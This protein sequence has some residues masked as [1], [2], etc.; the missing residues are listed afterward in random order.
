MKETTLL[1]AALICSLAGLIALFYISAKI[2]FKDYKPGELSKNAGESV[3]LE[4]IVSKIRQAE[5][6]AFIEVNFE[7]PVTI[8]IFNDKNLTL[9]AGD[10]IEIFGKVED[11]NGKEEIIAQRIRVIE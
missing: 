1:K 5:N 6:A 10:K 9:K 7:T 8:V 2:D 4:G 3:K 11:Y